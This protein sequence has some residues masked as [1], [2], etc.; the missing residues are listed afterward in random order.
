MKLG[1]NGINLSERQRQC[2]SIA[3]VA[4]RKPD[5]LVLG[6]P[7]SVLDFETEEKLFGKLFH[8]NQGK[9]VVVVSHHL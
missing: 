1:E 6:V 5:I 2:L 4:V 9:T 8:H 7:T 3:R